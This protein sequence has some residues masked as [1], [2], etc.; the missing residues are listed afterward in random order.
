MRK[1]ELQMRKWELHIYS[2]YWYIFGGRNGPSYLLSEIT[3]FTSNSSHN[4]YF[5]LVCCT[6]KLLIALWSYEN[7]Q[8][9]F[10]FIFI[11]SEDTF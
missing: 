11:V 3:Q 7:L 10:C 6:L 8:L 5:L 4:M 2:F 9:E 1:W